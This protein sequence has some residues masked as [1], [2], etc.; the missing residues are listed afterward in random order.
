MSIASELERLQQAKADIKAVIEQNWGSSIPANIKFDEYYNYITS[1]CIAKY[2]AGYEEGYAAG[3]GGGGQESHS[4]SASASSSATPVGNALIIDGSSLDCDGT[5]YYDETNNWYQTQDGTFRLS[6]SGLPDSEWSIYNMSSGAFLYTKIVESESVSEILG[7]TAWINEYSFENENLTITLVEASSSSEQSSSLSPSSSG[8]GSSSPSDII[9]GDRV[10]VTLSGQDTWL[11]CNPTYLYL[12]LENPAATGTSRKWVGAFDNGME[13][14]TIAIQYLANGNH[15]AT[16]YI[17]GVLTDYMSDADIYLNSSGNWI[18]NFED[19]EHSITFS[20]AQDN[21]PESYTATGADLSGVDG[22]YT[23]QNLQVA[24]NAPGPV[25]KN[26]NNF[27]I[28]MW[29]QNYGAIV[30][31]LYSLQDPFQYYTTSTGIT[32]TWM[33]ESELETYTAPVVVEGS[34]G[35]SSQEEVARASNVYGDGVSR[36]I[37]GDTPEELRHSALINGDEE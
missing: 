21:L 18:H 11:Q 22:T 9:Q 37:T 19:N 16:W 25:Y 26:S 36:R 14:S 31:D 35:G 3:G 30:N 8:S 28:C 23:R 34:G 17:Q 13:S 4:E 7:T 33:P 5:Y 20:Y 10:I 1:A 24:F 6:Y 29:S 15:G 27:M 2:N 32:G 12:H